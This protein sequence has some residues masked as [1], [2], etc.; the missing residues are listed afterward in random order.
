MADK[1]LASTRQQQVADDD[2]V[3]TLSHPPAGTLFH[4]TN[5]ARLR[6][7]MLGVAMVV[8]MMAL[9]P[10]LNRYHHLGLAVLVEPGLLANFERIRG[11]LLLI[12]TGVVLVIW[13]LSFMLANLASNIRRARCYPPPG[14]KVLFTTELVV[15]K[16]SDWIKRFCSISAILLILLAVIMFVGLVQFYTESSALQAALGDFAAMFH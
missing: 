5:S 3:S 15:G 2:W 9:I 16:E 13:Y 11:Y 7:V 4:P 8:P 14:S 10:L 6:A 12:Y 1:G